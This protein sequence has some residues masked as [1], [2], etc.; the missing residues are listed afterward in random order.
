MKID[1]K[2][3]RVDEGDKVNLDKWPTRVDPV[4]KSKADYKT[5]LAKHV[6]QLSD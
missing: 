4:Y 1:I 2:D 6:E 5:M 3:F